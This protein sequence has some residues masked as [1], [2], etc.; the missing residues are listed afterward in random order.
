MKLVTSRF[1]HDVIGLKDLSIGFRANA[2]IS[3][4]KSY[5]IIDKRIKTKEKKEK[6][7]FKR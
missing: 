3:I 7:Y 6:K 2:T 1:V 5:N 4:Q